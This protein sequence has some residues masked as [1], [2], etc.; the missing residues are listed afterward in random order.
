MKR[1][2]LHNQWRNRY[3]H[4]NQKTFFSVFFLFPIQNFLF[5]HIDWKKRLP[6]HNFFYFSVVSFFHKNNSYFFFCS[7]SHTPNFASHK[8]TTTPPYLIGKCLNEFLKAISKE[9]SI[10]LDKGKMICSFVV[11]SHED[12]Y[13][14][15]Q[16]TR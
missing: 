10:C 8:T 12:T 9:D 2:L 3:N 15:Q 16:Y 14:E 6:S 11:S 5:F 1:D 4:Q 13:S 7:L